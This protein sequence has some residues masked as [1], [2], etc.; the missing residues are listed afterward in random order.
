MLKLNTCIL[1]KKKVNM[2]RQ[3]MGTGHPDT[4]LTLQL[5]PFR[6]NDRTHVDHVSV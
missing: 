2:V 6:S 1:K 4:H 3:F 5:G